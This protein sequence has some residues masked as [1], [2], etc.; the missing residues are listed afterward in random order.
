[1]LDKAF[2]F[3][4]IF[5]G[6]CRLEARVHVDAHQFGMT[7][8]PDAL[9]IVRADATAKQEGFAAVVVLKHRPVELLSAA[10][11]GLAFRVES[12]E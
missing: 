1:M 5:Q 3:L 10:A 7:E 6:R 11:Y 9:G 4:D 2:Q 12:T 8:Q